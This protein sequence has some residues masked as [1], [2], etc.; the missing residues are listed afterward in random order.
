MVQWFRYETTWAYTKVLTMCPGAATLS[1]YILL[2]VAYVVSLGVV[3][4][5]CNLLMTK[6]TQVVQVVLD[7]LSNI[8]RM[9]EDDI[10]KDLLTLTLNQA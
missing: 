6:D 2:Q 7:G 4:P 1:V 8:L 3:T 10:D 5:M 9:A